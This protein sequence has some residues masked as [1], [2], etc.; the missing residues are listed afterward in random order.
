MA[1]KKKKTPT[2]KPKITTPD[3]TAFGLADIGFQNAAKNA[4][5]Q[6]A[7]SPISPAQKLAADLAAM[8][9]KTNREFAL[10]D[11]EATQ[12]QA[13]MD[14]LNRLFI[15][16]I[17]AKNEQ[18]RLR[19]QQEADALRNQLRLSQ[20][21]LGQ[22]IQTSATTAD[23]LKASKEANDIMA[24][25]TAKF[26]T[27]GLASLIPKIKE[28]A[29][30][31]A[32]EETIKAELANTEEYKL[33][34]SANQDRLKKNLTILSPAE[35][36][37]VEDAYRQT[38]RAYG[39]TQFDN[40]AYVKQFISNDVSPTELSNRVVMA[41]QR[42]RNADPA[43][44]TQL[45]DYY[46][47]GDTDLV[48]YVLDPSQQFQ[49]IQRQVAAAEIGVAAGRQG[50]QAGVNVAEQLAAQGVTQAEAQKGYATIADIL[51]TA[52]KLSSIYGTTLEGYDQAAAEQEVFNSLASAQRARQKLTARELAQFSGSSGM[53][54]A[55][56]SEGKTAGQI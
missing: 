2:P 43:I 32:G 13:A 38:L 31:G 40:D 49:K 45:K 8:E 51:P 25:L 36:L 46:G 50:L 14:E 26:T 54:K 22:K 29:V 19:L 30:S 21:A 23:E 15:E 18:E 3:N 5:A 35:Y 1:T 17:N 47:I 44:Q 24:A 56:L 34:F 37:A 48:A 9:E 33:R 10:M 6:I 4:A 39:L 41:V 11:E 16:G 55:S 42:V 53:S 20:I 27:Y 12:V 52:E 28:L 7:T